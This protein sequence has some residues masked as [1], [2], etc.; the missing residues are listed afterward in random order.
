MIFKK[1]IYEVVFLFIVILGVGVV[2]IESI[3]FLGEMC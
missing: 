3:C 1:K 2:L